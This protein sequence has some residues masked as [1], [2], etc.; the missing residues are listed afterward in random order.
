MCRDLLFH[1]QEHQYMLPEIA[2]M[3]DACGLEFLGLSDLPAEALGRYAS[4]FPDDVPRTNIAY[5]DRYE[6]QYP[7]TFSRMFL[8]W[9]RAPL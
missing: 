9:C 2:E 3:L 8:F 1:V 4:M 7:R 5:W 6:E